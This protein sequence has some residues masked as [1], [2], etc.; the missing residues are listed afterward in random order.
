MTDFLTNLAARTIAAPSLRPRS[1]MRFE[2]AADGEPPLSVVQNDAVP[3]RIAATE[4]PASAEPAPTVSRPEPAVSPAPAASEPVQA[5]PAPPRAALS[6]RDSVPEVET[7]VVREPVIDTRV[8]REPSAARERVVEQVTQTEVERVI[9]RREVPVAI[10]RT[11]AA[12]PPASTRPHRHDEQPP[13]LLRE[14]IVREEK[15]PIEAEPARD[16]LHERV[17]VRRATPAPPE[18]AP[19]RRQPPVTPASDAAKAEPV[20]QVSIGRIEVR[21]STPPA[22]PRPEPRRSS[23]MTIDDYVAKRKERP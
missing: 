15:T 12:V 4:P 5:T 10:E 14:E 8:L 23:V 20:I 7:R 17:V 3:R 2:P 19:G 16:R 18:R 21:A 1:R 22:A 13:V 6:A 9:E 11:P